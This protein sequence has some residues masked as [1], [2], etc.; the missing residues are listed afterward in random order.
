MN[1]SEYLEHFRNFLDGKKDDEDFSRLALGREKELSIVASLNLDPVLPI[2]QALLLPDG[3]EKALQLSFHV[4][5]LYFHDPAQDTGDK[6]MDEGSP[7]QRPVLRSLRFR[8]RRHARSIRLLRLFAMNHPRTVPEARR[9]NAEE[10][11]VQRDEA[12]KEPERG[13]GQAQGRTR[14]QPHEIGDRFQ[15]TPGGGRQAQARRHAE[16][17]GRPAFPGRH[18]PVSRGRR[19][20]PYGRPRGFR[21]RIDHE[22]RGLAEGNADVRLPEPGNLQMRSRQ[23]LREPD[24]RFPPGSRPQSLRFL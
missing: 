21:R 6:P 24:R 23:I 19:L 1:H 11:Q 22:N 3:Q 2:L 5:G 4:P 8:P 20:F 14:P 9:R 17:T 12:P 16:N 13:E 18:H 7:L 15:K 10:K